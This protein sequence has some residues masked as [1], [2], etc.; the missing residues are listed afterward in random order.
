MKKTIV[1]LALCLA[2]AQ[3]AL[4][5]S[6]TGGVTTVFPGGS[7]DTGCHS[8]PTAGTVAGFPLT[9]T[10]YTCWNYSDGWGFAANGY[11]NIGTVGTWSETGKITI[12]LPSLQSMVGGFLN[13]APGHGTP[14]ITALA[15]DGVTV[16]ESWDLSAAMPITVYYDNQGAYRGISRPSADIGYLQ[17]QGAY[18]AIHSITVGGN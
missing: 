9:A 16:L 18:I 1:L 7:F 12:K 6:V 8:G 15:A 4:K 17:I 11:W 10:D 2:P 5:G 3:A 13:Y 14:R